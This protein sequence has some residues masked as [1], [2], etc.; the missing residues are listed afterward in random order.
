MV[1]NPSASAGDTGDGG[2]IPGSGRFPGG[3]RGNPLQYSRLENPM[4]VGRGAWRLQSVS[5]QRVRHD[6][7]DLARRHALLDQENLP[8]TE[9]VTFCRGTKKPGDAG[10]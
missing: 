2:S 6:R 5:L 10:S 4:G 3:G 1:K 7:S 8:T 9:L